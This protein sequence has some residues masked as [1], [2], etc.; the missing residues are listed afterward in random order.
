[1][2]C[3]SLYATRKSTFHVTRNSQKSVLNACR[4]V[5]LKVSFMNDIIKKGYAERAPKEYKKAWYIPHHGVYNPKKPD[6]IR[7]V[8]D[9]SPDFMG[10]SLNR[11]LLQGPDITNS[12]VGVL[13]RFRQE[14]VA[15]TCDIEGVFHQVKVNKGHRD[16]LR[17]LWWV[18]GDT[19]QE[20]KEYRM[21][22]HL[23]GA[24]SS[25]ACANLSL[26]MTAEDNKDL[27]E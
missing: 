27:G 25:P 20:L 19:T 5:L 24:A 23:F 8:F 15:F 21:R 9:C 1:M 14:P 16:F 18:E 13:C 22:V 10:H 17:F 12:L 26:K 7:V 11:Y 6:K 3:P 4:D 2:R